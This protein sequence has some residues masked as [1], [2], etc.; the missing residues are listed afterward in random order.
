MTLVGGFVQNP[1]HLLYIIVYQ[2]HLCVWDTHELKHTHKNTDTSSRHNY[3]RFSDGGKI[4]LRKTDTDFT[5]MGLVVPGNFCRLLHPDNA[6]KQQKKIFLLI[7]ESWMYPNNSFIFLTEVA[8]VQIP[9]NV[10][11]S[12]DMPSRNCFKYGR[13][14]QGPC[15]WLGL[16]HLRYTNVP[17]RSNNTNV[18]PS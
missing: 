13:M 9:T 2:Y 10:L 14:V 18:H 5:T 11:V 17:L 1:R 15:P 7:P 16:I 12:F 4:W 6:P 3:T 8:P